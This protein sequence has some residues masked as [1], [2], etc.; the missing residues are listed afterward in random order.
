[1]KK[2]EIFNIIIDK[3]CEVCEV[4]R[5]SMMS[6]SKVQA[7]VD[8][9]ILGVQYLRRTGMSFEEIALYVL[10][11]A[12]GDADLC[13][14]I[15]EVRRKAKGMRRLFGSYTFRCYESKMF[16]MLSRTI[17]NDLK[18]LYEDVN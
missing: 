1:M 12:A 17:L 6:S 3:V 11:E 8:A 7:I 4:R 18:D 16:Q 13:P 5:E 15:N 9:R 2:S 10:R 14:P